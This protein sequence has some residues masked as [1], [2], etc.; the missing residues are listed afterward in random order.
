MNFDLDGLLQVLQLGT[1]VLAVGGI[2][3]LRAF[4]QSEIS[5][6]IK[7]LREDIDDLREDVDELRAHA[8][9]EA[10]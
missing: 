4:V 3:A 2:A 5:K 8:G 10:A 9:L 6:T 7:P 1:G